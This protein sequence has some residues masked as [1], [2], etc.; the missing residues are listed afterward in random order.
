MIDKPPKYV[1]YHIEMYFCCFYLYL[2]FIEFSS[3]KKLLDIDDFV[4]L[5]LNKNCVK[6][7]KRRKLLFGVLKVEYF[8]K[9]I[10][11]ML[12]YVSMRLPFIM[13]I[14]RMRSCCL[15]SRLSKYNYEN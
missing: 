12:S 5:P 1:D 2:Y 15:T 9:I 10:K 6:I 7:F 3:F 11:K 8:I 14:N 13:D 4:F